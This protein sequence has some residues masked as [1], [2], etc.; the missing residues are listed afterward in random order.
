MALLIGFILLLVSGRMPTCRFGPKFLLVSGVPAMATLDS[1]ALFTGLGLSEHKAR[2][3]LKNAVLSTQLRDAATQ[4]RAPLPWQG[5]CPKA[6]WGLV[7]IP[8]CAPCPAVVAFLTGRGAFPLIP[9][10]SGSADSGLHHRQSYRNPS[11]WL[12]FPTQGYQA[13]LFPRELYSQ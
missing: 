13:S 6:A 9:L 7:Q 5:W 11:I 4:V 8:T 10:T 1:L 3:T 2:E 12:S